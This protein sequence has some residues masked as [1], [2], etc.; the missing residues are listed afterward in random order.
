MLCKIIFAPLDVKL[1]LHQAGFVKI[2]PLNHKVAAE[3][4]FP[5]PVKVSCEVFVIKQNHVYV[6]AFTKTH[7]VCP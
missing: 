2:H 6:P 5:F 7:F 1:K 3:N 4:W